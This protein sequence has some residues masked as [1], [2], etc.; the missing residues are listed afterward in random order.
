[1][2]S[3]SAADRPAAWNHGLTAFVVKRLCLLIPSSEGQHE[4]LYKQQPAQWGDVL[5]RYAIFQRLRRCIGESE[6]DHRARQA[7]WLR[8]RRKWERDNSAFVDDVRTAWPDDPDNGAFIALGTWIATPEQIAGSKLEYRVAISP[9]GRVLVI[10][11]ASDKD[12]LIA[13]ISNLIDR[14]RQAAGIPAAS[15]RG[16][17][18]RPD[19]K[20]EAM[21]HIWPELID[22]ARCE[23]GLKPGPPYPDPDWRPDPVNSEHR[24]FLKSIQDH[25]VVPLWDLQLAG[26]ANRKLAT[27]RALYPGISEKRSLLAKLRRAGELQNEAPLWVPRLRANVGG[28]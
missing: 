14:E 15:R 12:L 18:R 25:Q 2:S 28:G 27:A 1:M 13:R 4:R 5:A 26:K 17:K 21:R 23:A 9:T 7:S 3:P 6:A 8:A 24:E 22:H 11:L 16:P 19:R 10:D 20:V